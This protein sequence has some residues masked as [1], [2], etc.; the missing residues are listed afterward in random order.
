W[1]SRAIGVDWLTKSPIL[2]FPGW[3]TSAS[4]PARQVAAKIATSLRG[5]EE[6]RRQGL[7]CGALGCRRLGWPSWASRSL[8]F[9]SNTWPE[10]RKGVMVLPPLSRLCELPKGSK[11]AGRPAC[12]AAGHWTV[13]A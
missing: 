11:Q 4:E 3:A 13:V 6:C 2:N 8:L 1:T 9:V 10:H 5:R 7:A 12:G